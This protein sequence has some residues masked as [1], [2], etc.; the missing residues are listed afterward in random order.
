[1]TLVVT[2]NIVVACYFKPNK[3]D[4]F[5]ILFY[6][7][8]VI[9][10]TLAVLVFIFIYQARKYHRAEYNQHKWGVFI[11]L[12]IKILFGA[13]VGVCVPR[14]MNLED[15]TR[16]CI[17]EI[18]YVL[19][20]LVVIFYKKNKDILISFSKLDDI[21]DLKTAYHKPI[22]PSFSGSILSPGQVTHREDM[23]LSS[24]LQMSFSNEQMAIIDN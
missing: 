21:S 24:F 15:T 19:S 18:S 6:R 9:N 10:G 11:Y 17:I 13:I 5:Y 14:M 2:Y 16:A 23:L 8:S 4:Q 12:A 20:D 22:N 1:M 3:H 7:D